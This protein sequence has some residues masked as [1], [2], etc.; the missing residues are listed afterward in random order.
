MV[1]TKKSIK[2]FNLPIVCN[3]PTSLQDYSKQNAEESAN[4]DKALEEGYEI[5]SILSL[6]LGNAGY[7]AFVLMKEVEVV[8]TKQVEQEEVQSDK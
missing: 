5:I 6:T 1:K 7:I 8:S 2:A 4:L 3:N